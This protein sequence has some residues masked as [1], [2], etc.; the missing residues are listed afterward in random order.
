MTTLKTYKRVVNTVMFGDF[1]KFVKDTYGHDIEVAA[2]QEA[3]NGDNLMF[4][5]TEVVLSPDDIE[6]FAEWKDSGD[7]WYFGIPTM[8]NCMVREGLIEA[9]YYNII[10]D[11]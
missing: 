5:A 7:F 6:E 10:V 11:W 9:G 2:M 8:L 4:F 1:E 3:R